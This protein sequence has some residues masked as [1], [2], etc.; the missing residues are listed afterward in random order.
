MTAAPREREHRTRPTGRLTPTYAFE[1][2]G[3]GH[4]ASGPAGIIVALAEQ[5]S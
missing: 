4:C 5:L 3:Y 2:G 1:L